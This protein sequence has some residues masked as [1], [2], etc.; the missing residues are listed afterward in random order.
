MKVKCIREYS[1]SYKI[2][3]IFE[4]WSYYMFEDHVRIIGNSTF[5][6]KKVKKYPYLYD[7]FIDI[8]EHRN[9]IIN[10]ILEN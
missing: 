6:I 5:S 2:G 7:Y 8:A 1:S 3:D 10:K 9:N 4:S